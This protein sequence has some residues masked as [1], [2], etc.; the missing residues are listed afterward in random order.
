MTAFVN[1]TH[2]ENLTTRKKLKLV[3]FQLLKSKIIK[4]SKR[5]KKKM[6]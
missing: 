4:E 5:V 3:K 6:F 1:K 2:R